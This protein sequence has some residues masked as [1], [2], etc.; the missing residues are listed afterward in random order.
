MAA[1]IRWPCVV[2]FAHTQLAGLG[3]K[4]RHSYEAPAGTCVSIADGHRLLLCYTHM[5]AAVGIGQAAIS[6]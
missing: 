5:C 2:E 3:G 6:V 4:G 1:D